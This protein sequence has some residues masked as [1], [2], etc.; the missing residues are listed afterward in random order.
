V[1]EHTGTGAHRH[2]IVEH[3]ADLLR[4]PEQPACIGIDMIIGLPREARSGGRA[5]DRAARALLGWPRSSSIFSPPCRA[6]LQADTYE[7]AAATNRASHPDE[8]GLTK[9][10]YYLFP[11]IRA[12]DTLI[13]PARQHRICE[14]HPECSFYVLNGNAPVDASKHT[15]EG[16][17]HRIHLLQDAGFEAVTEACSAYPRRQAKRDDILDAHA[18]C[19]TARR[20]HK[21]TAARLP[22]TD[23]V[24]VDPTGLRMEIWR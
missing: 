9:Q 6:A 5:C 7:T 17:E 8:V 11:K 19:Y 12:L 10:A 18:A 24:P 23:S 16:I 21:G 1:L 4:L 14:V 22:E 15:D 13:T 3:T 2:R 20:V